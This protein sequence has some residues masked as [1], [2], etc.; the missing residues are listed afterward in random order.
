[1][2]ITIP[3][4]LFTIVNSETSNE[5]M[6]EVEI[7]FMGETIG[8]VGGSRYEDTCREAA[9]RALR[10]VFEPIIA[11]IRNHKDVDTT[12]RFDFEEDEFQIAA[13]PQTSDFFCGAQDWGKDDDG[14]THV[15]GTCGLLKGHEGDWH[16]EVRDG[17]LWAS[18]RGPHDRKAPTP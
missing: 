15:Y 18:W 8:Y 17:K 11:A 9:E 3:E 13:F 14:G 2:A 7:K 6:A 1:M 10:D 5:I 16:S 12:S 4:P